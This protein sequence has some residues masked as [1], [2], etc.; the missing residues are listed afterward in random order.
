[1]TTENLGRIMQLILSREEA[2]KMAVEK[3]PAP[4][5]APKAAP[6]PAPKKGK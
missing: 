3:K 1:L 4:K 6:K 5:V 2:L